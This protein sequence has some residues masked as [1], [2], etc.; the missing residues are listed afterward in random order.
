LLKKP[1]ELL[2]RFVLLLAGMIDAAWI[3]RELPL[4][5]ASVHKAI[6][7]GGGGLREG[8]SS[9]KN[10]LVSLI[11]FLTGK[12][13]GGLWAKNLQTILVKVITCSSKLKNAGKSRRKEEEEEEEDS[14]YFLCEAE[15]ALLDEHLPGIM[16]MKTRTIQLKNEPHALKT[17]KHK[18]KHENSICG[19]P[20]RVYTFARI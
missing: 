7:I 19:E 2:H 8:S 1:T 12:G 15:H 6:N 14:F 10:L 3:P 17:H 5:Q 4:T 20:C 9:S 16:T 13:G 11:D 18:Q